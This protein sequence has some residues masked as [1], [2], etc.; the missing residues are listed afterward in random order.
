M[1]LGE[2]DERLAALEF[3]FAPWC[4][5]LDVGLQRV[6]AQFKPHLVVPLAG[7]AVT[8]GVGTDLAC[9]LDLL[10]GDERPSDRRAQQ[11]VAFILS[12]RP[13]HREDEVAHELFA[14]ILDED[15]F[16]PHAQH[17]RLAPRGFDF[18][19][20]AEVGGEGHDLRIIFSL[21]PFEDDRGV[22]PARISEHDLHFSVRHYFGSNIQSMAPRAVCIRFSAWFQTAE[23]GPSI[24]DVV[25]S[26]PRRAGRQCMNQALGANAI[27]A[28][29]TRNGS[30]AARRP[31]LS[32][33]PIETHTSV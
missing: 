8:D 26:S 14:Q 18:L 9:N 6:I 28:S 27:S 23:R 7:R 19:A 30:N 12:I 2:V 32:S 5:H 21:Q 10:L 33:P 17:L 29:S 20:L 15:V 22:K 24:T 31:S 4:D 11:I 16:G 1:F 13:E 3:P 25:T